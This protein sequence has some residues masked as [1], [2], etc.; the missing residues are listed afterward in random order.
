M[1]TRSVAPRLRAGAALARGTCE[2]RELSA[3]PV[4]ADALRGAGCGNS[5]VLAHGREEG[6]AHVRGWRVC[7]PVLGLRWVPL[8]ARH[9]P[10]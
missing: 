8:A 4:L 2:P 10:K 7:D 5:G 1:R 6:A 9:P 3:A